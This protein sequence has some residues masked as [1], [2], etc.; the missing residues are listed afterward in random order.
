MFNEKSL[1]Y[2]F[3]SQPLKQLMLQKS[4]VNTY[5][6]RSNTRFNWF[7]PTASNVV[8]VQSL[9]LYYPNFFQM[10]PELKLFGCEEYDPNYNCIDSI[11]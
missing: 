1:Q 9:K 3:L 6:Q 5:E 2:V 8:Y 10:S 11:G 7:N 4:V